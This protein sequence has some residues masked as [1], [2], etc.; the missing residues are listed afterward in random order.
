M[1]DS[2]SQL[3]KPMTLRILLVVLALCACLFFFGLVRSTGDGT[4]SLLITALVFVSLAGLVAVFLFTVLVHELGHYF[5][6]RLCGFKFYG[7]RLITLELSRLSTGMTLRTV[8]NTVGAA[9]VIFMAPTDLNHILQKRRVFILAGP[10]ASL[11]LGVVAYLGFERMGGIVDFNQ[12]PPAFVL[13]QVFLWTS[14]L[15]FISGISSLVAILPPK[16]KAVSDGRHLYLSFKKPEAYRWEVALAMV[17]IPWTFG[18]RARDWDAAAIDYLVANAS[19]PRLVAMANLIAYYNLVDRGDIAGGI[20]RIQ[21][22]IKAAE[23]IADPKVDQ[24]KELY[25]EAAYAFAHFLSDPDFGREMLTRSQASREEGYSTFDRAEAAIRW[26]DGDD[27]GA[28]EAV[29]SAETK[30]LAKCPPPLQ[31]NIQLER[32]L[33]L[34]VVKESV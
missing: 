8:K 14:A 5:V 23:E 17:A 10:V 11:L 1:A 34:D 2:T 7:L 24:F 6:G 3:K 22:A 31:D 33:I 18:V 20:G 27:D 25:M 28:R 30:L 13:T 12:P 32:K 21:A 19:E 9:G 26:A 4:K 29:A 15:S 16:R